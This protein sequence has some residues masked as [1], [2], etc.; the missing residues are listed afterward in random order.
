MTFETHEIIQFYK[1][2]LEYSLFINNVI[3]E[4]EPK[5]ID[6]FQRCGLLYS[7]KRTKNNP[8]VMH[9]RFYSEIAIKTIMGNKKQVYVDHHV[10][11]VYTFSKKFK[12]EN[13]KEFG[14]KKKLLKI[15]EMFNLCNYYFGYQNWNTELV[16]RLTKESGADI[17]NGKMKYFVDSAS[18]SRITFREYP[19]FEIYGKG[20]SRVGGYDP[21]NVMKTSIKF[22][23]TS[24]LKEAFKH[25]AIDLTVIVENG[26]AYKIVKPLTDFVP[27]LE[28]INLDEENEE[29]VERL[30]HDEDEVN[31]ADYQDI[32]DMMDKEEENINVQDEIVNIRDQNEIVNA[33]GQDKLMNIEGQDKIVDIG[34]ENEIEELKKKF[35]KFRGMDLEE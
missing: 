22:S 21:C 29:E 19:R 3:P 7:A 8:N 35:R 9:Y 16:E 17:V 11:R 13:S 12:E 30:D 23:I 28:Y 18:I 33:E 32:L 14:Y 10:Y 31:P 5:I 1:P 15:N 6:I 2:P 25:L 24:S 4:D 20:K 34:G 27:T 26:Q